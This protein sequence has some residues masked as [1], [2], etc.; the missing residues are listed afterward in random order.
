MIPRRKLQIRCYDIVEWISALFSSGTWRQVEV[1]D[2]EKA[3]A[4]YL[5][6]QYACATSSGRDAIALAFE[7][8]GLQSGDEIIIPSYTL[9]E[10]MPI[11][12]SKGYHLIPADVD[13]ESFNMDLASLKARLSKRT[14]AIIALH[15]FG[16][17]CDIE[18]IMGFAMQ[19]SLLVLE[20]CAHALGA[21]VNGKKLGSFGDAAIFSFEVNKAVSTYG[22]GM[23]VTN[24][25][26]VFD[27]AKNA[28]A[29]RRQTTLP[30]L[31]KALSTWIEELVIRSPFY[32]L[33]NHI[34]FSEQMAPVFE[35]FYRRAHSG[36]RPSVAYSGYQ[37][38]LGLRKLKM[39][40]ERN[41]KCNQQWLRLSKDLH[42]AYKTQK[43]CLFGTPAFYNYVALSKA[44]PP[45]ELRK[46]LRRYGVDIGIGTEVMDDCARLIG[47]DDCPVV[48]MLSHEAVLLP[49]YE[50]LTE[51]EYAKMVIALNKIGHE[52]VKNAE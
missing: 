52:A 12:R 11:L 1:E 5:G 41:K 37:A 23:L 21:H 28:V 36:Q 3:F 8:M 7:G 43:R 13:P 34:L 47:Y 35:A 15:I 22:G 51:K 20:D 48:N 27:F 25:E 32:G 24:R 38:C 30:A 6:V 19:N 49:Q 33:I 9:G 10:L 39:V 2:F 50:A 40:D 31:K 16:A 29:A 44:M 42:K 14:K 46:K 17:P 26:Q 4:V 18:G 45:V